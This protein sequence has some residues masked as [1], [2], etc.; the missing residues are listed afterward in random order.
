MGPHTERMLRTDIRLRTTPFFLFVL[1][2]AV[3]FLGVG[4]LAAVGY[5]ASIGQ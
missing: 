3:S 4:I 1:L 5:L 2:I